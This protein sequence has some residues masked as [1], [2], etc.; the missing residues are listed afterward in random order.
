MYNYISAA[1]GK[2]EAKKL[3]QETNNRSLK[4]NVNELNN[5]LS[6]LQKSYE[7]LEQQY[8]SHFMESGGS[9]EKLKDVSTAYNK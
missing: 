7:E 6:K 3:S 5:N 4:S 9:I 2:L 8:K 1:I